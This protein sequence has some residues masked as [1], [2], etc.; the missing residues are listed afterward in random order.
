M[1]CDQPFTAPTVGYAHSESLPTLTTM[2]QADAPVGSTYRYAP[3]QG[4]K[5]LQRYLKEPDGTETD[6]SEGA[7]SADSYHYG[8]PPQPE[9]MVEILVWGPRPAPRYIIIPATEVKPGQPRWWGPTR[10]FV[11]SQVEPDGS[12]LRGPYGLHLLSDDLRYATTWFALVENVPPDAPSPA[13]SPKR[14]KAPGRLYTVIPAAELAPG[15]KA[16]RWHA[17]DHAD[18]QVRALNNGTDT[19]SPGWNGEWAIVK[20]RRPRSVRR[21]KLQAAREALAAASSAVTEAQ[22]ELPDQVGDASEEV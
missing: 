10:A 9:Q 1:S 5:T 2:R 15:E 7:T 6:V 12:A 11:E 20:A 8:W 16:E 19:W 17:R 22:A 13:P 21:A 4:H 18:T 3:P 14:V